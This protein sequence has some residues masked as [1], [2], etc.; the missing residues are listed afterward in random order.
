M[1][2][3]VLSD[4]AAWRTFGSSEEIADLLR[5]GRYWRVRPI[6]RRTIMSYRP[7]NS[8][9]QCSLCDAMV[10]S[11]EGATTGSGLSYIGHATCNSL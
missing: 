4:G 8:E 5:L 1:V 9:E 11:E 3:A 10:T 6:K 2:N 7:V